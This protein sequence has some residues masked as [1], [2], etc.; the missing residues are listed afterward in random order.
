MSFARIPRFGISN[1]KKVI[2]FESSKVA[3]SYKNLPYNPYFYASR[4]SVDAIM[5][6]NSDK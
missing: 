4:Y 3:K 6:A 5:L 2:F 1:I